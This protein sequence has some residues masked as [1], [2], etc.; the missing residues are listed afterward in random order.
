M[1]AG[2]D[3]STMG[4]AIVR[5]PSAASAHRWGCQGPDAAEPNASTL[6]PSASMIAR[7][8][9]VRSAARGSRA[10]PV[11]YAI[12]APSGD[13]YGDPADIG[14]EHGSVGWQPTISV[15]AEPSE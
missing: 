5:Q 8:Q 6:E 13:Q 11:V 14:P 10:Q 2:C 9:P 7:W 1:G 15:N 12:W 3:V 4:V